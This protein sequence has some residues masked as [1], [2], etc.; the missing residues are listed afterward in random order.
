MKLFIKFAI[1]ISLLSGISKAWAQTTY[2][3]GAS[4]DSDPVWGGAYWRY[5]DGGDDVVTSGTELIA[6]INA[7]GTYNATKPYII[8]IANDITISAAISLSNKNIVLRKVTRQDIQ[9]SFGSYYQATDNKYIVQKYWDYNDPWFDTNATSPEL[10]DGEPD[11]GITVTDINSHFTMSGAENSLTTENITLYGRNTYLNLTGKS[12]LQGGG[13]YISSNQ[14]ITLACNIAGVGAESNTASNNRHSAVGIYSGTSGNIQSITFR[15]G[16]I[17]HNHAGAFGGAAF[18]WNGGTTG[19]IVFKGYTIIEDN[20]S[21]SEGGAFYKNGTGASLDI[22]DNVI[23]RNNTGGDG[24]ALHM[25]G[26]ITVNLRNNVLFEGNR[27]LS[28]PK[29]AVL[30]P[31]N[32]GAIWIAQYASS[33]T[34]IVNIYDNVTFRNNQAARGGGAIAMGNSSSQGPGTLTL[35]GG[36]FENN[37]ALGLARDLGSL[38]SY[39]VADQ[40]AIGGGGA[41]YAYKTTEIKIPPTSTVHFEGNYASV[42][43]YLDNTS[44]QQKTTG[45]SFYAND[46]Y[47]SHIQNP[48]VHTSLINVHGQTGWDYYNLYNNYDI[49]TPNNIPNDLYAIV[50]LSLSPADGRGGSIVGDINNH[51]YDILGDGHMWAESNQATPLSYTA[52][53]VAGYEFSGWQVTSSNNILLS[54]KA[55]LLGLASSATQ[56]QIDA[57]LV[58]PVLKLKVSSFDIYLEARFVKQAVLSITPPSF[59]ILALDETEDIADVTP[60]YAAQPFSVSNLGE[61]DAVIT[62]VELVGTDAG[63]F[64]LTG[65]TTGTIAAG[66][67]DET[68]WTL[69]PDQE[70]IPN[71]SLLNTGEFISYAATFRI[72]YSGGKTAEVPVIFHLIRKPGIIITGEYHFDTHVK[73]SP[74]VIQPVSLHNY[75]VIN[76]Q[77]TVI[78]VASAVNISTGEFTVDDSGVFEVGKNAVFNVS[79]TVEESIANGVDKNDWLVRLTSPM[80]DVIPG[81]YERWLVVKYIS[82]DNPLDIRMTTVPITVSVINPAE[83]SFDETRMA[84][85]L[86]DLDD[87][88]EED[89][90]FTG[91]YKEGYP[92]SPSDVTIAMLNFGQVSAVIETVYMENEAASVFEIR[93]KE[94]GKYIPPYAD[95][96]AGLNTNYAVH[97]KT[98]L[99]QGSY[100][101]FVIVKYQD[102]TDTQKTLRINVIF[103]VE[104]ADIWNFTLSGTNHTFDNAGAGY[105]EVSPQTVTINNTGNRSSEKMIIEFVNPTSD[106]ILST[107]TIDNIA[108][109]GTGTFTVRPSLGLPTGTY[110]AQIRVKYDMTDIVDDTSDNN[111]EYSQKNNNFHFYIV[112]FTVE[113][114]IPSIE[115]DASVCKD[116]TGVTYTTESGQKNYDW[117]VSSGGEIT[118]GLGTN[119][120]TVTWS[121]A[122]QID[123]LVRVR[124]CPGS[125]DQYTSFTRYEVEIKQAPTV[126]NISVESM[127][128]AGGTLNLYPP[129]VTTHGSS[130]SDGNKVWKLDNEEIEMPYM[131]NVSDNGKTL[132]YV[133]TSECGQESF[134]GVTLDVRTVP[135]IAA[136]TAPTGVCNN[137]SLTLTAPMTTSSPAF[138][139]Q[140]WKLDAGNF[141]SGY[142]VTYD[143]NDKDL[144]YEA[145]N[146]CGTNKSNTVQITVY[147][148]PVPSFVSGA[149][150]AAP[151][152]GGMVYTTQSG[153][154]DYVWGITNG[155]ITSGGNG[156]N[157]ATVTWDTEETGGSISVTYKSAAGCPAASP[158][159]QPVNFEPQTNPTIGG[160]TTVCPTSNNEYTYT[161]EKNKFDYAWTITGGAAVTATDSGDG[162]PTIK[163]TWTSG[164]TGEV[165][166]SY[167]HTNDAGLPLVSKDK[168]I[169][170]QTVTSITTQ[171]L[172]GTDCF[173]GSVSLSVAVSCQDNTATYQWK[174]GGENVGVASSNPGYP[175]TESGAYTVEVSGICG[176]V[177]S[178][179][180]VTVTIK[181]KPAATL[182]DITSAY[183]TQEVTYT[184]DGGSVGDAGTYNWDYTGATLVSGGTGTD[185]TITVKWTTTGTKTISVDYTVDGCPTTTATKNVTVVAQGQPIIDDG[186]PVTSVC[187]GASQSYATASNKYNYYWTVSGGSVT[188]G[189]GTATA[190]ITW[191]GVGN[192]TVKVEYSEALA[193]TAVESEETTVTIND[194]PSI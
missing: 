9:P 42:A 133:V 116:D 138:T 134:S 180:A 156:N 38:G 51:L 88:G 31:S 80:G 68:K 24:G 54:E 140:G 2:S 73:G 12:P 190:S 118:A 60:W 32:G 62:G 18:H 120:I 35:Y 159:T 172:G 64:T 6:A 104:A 176:T 17:W 128:C 114:V 106:F 188:T 49:G 177:T 16:V 97:V 162:Y 125:S 94:V 20:Y 132:K 194:Q 148:T 98:G 50:N 178:S 8:P 181:D 124:Y 77:I 28:R 149:D 53:P 193:A 108:S 46:D 158:A 155:A 107:E 78:A 95:S 34:E 92:L 44:L 182:T 169:T 81:D 83:V 139:S 151:G 152:Q 171:P 161:T 79:A 123:N 82:T 153:M 55:T 143:Q 15:G 63:K 174:K 137:T 122:S 184:T 43:S 96:N 65:S 109:G 71:P 52:V 150:E 87:D 72:T 14:K 33:S 165:S 69:A 58:K 36:R 85:N 164:G 102:G 99:T 56:A 141:T 19:S 66:Q 26:G 131:L 191:G 121:G 110:T 147:P 48:N 10:Y 70:Q 105:S 74:S 163:V 115:G 40:Y 119:E 187:F 186:D 75:G 166:V 29:V 168:D 100:S 41:I 117:R 160:T 179:P 135:S 183:T 61:M 67:T 21:E 136:I 13:I 86:D 1:T 146:V 167:R 30:F 142:A 189:Q 37:S 89:I 76:G 23:F 170:K 3:D 25:Q 127:Y 113:S 47:I 173:G 91:V 11:F 192:G 7:T 93:D 126:G 185:K 101:D 103:E 59:D 175:A 84:A 145:A 130:V 111:D 144:Y 27:T 39:S 154:T 5:S 157:T 22:I 112:S 57:E 90:V 45:N 129:E 4:Y